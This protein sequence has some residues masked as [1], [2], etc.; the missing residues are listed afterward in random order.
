MLR[1]KDLRHLLP[2]AWNA[3]GLPPEDLKPIM[4]W[5]AGSNMSERYTTARISGDRENLDR[6]AAFLGLDRLRLAAG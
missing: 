5:T 6:V 4:G 2:T 3:L 1:F